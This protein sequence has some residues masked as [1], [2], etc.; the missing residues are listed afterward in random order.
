MPP[1][2]TAKYHR[3]KGAVLASHSAVM[4]NRAI[5]SGTRYGAKLGSKILL[6]V[7]ETVQEGGNLAFCIAGRFNADSQCKN[8]TMATPS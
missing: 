4:H 8:F 1:D 5:R 2:P 3:H 6:V 7:T